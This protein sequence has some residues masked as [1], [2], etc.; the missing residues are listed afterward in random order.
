MKKNPFLGKL[1]VFDGLDGSGLTTQANLLVKKIN[2]FQKKRAFLLKE[3]TSGLIGGL[4]RGWLSHDWRSS[5]E[6]L[7]L[8]F[9]ADRAYQL[10]KEITP[11]LRKGKIVVL[12]RYVFSSI[13]F[14]GID[15]D[16]RWLKEINKNFLLPDLTFFLKVSPKIC[17]KR[18]KENRYEIKLFEKENIL[19]KVWKHFETLSREFQNIFVIN[20]E[21]EIEEISKE[22]FEI[23]SKNIK[24]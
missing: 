4:I 12:D 14:G 8:L 15:L 10:E 2:K 20:G 3:P 7:Q 16:K 19:E 13:A 18:I 11:L 6:C 1:I 17:L 5:P 24:I 22:I 21:R 23:F 9:A